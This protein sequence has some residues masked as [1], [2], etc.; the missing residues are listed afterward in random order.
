M[1]PNFLIQVEQAN[2]LVKVRHCGLPSSLAWS[3]SDAE[4]H[5]MACSTSNPARMHRKIPLNGPG[6]PPNL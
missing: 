2:S 4:V 6:L 1:E 3:L 5:R